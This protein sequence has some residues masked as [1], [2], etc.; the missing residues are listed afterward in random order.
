MTK[1]CS[2]EKHEAINL[3]V[4]KVL[5]VLLK[6][7]ETKFGDEQYETEFLGDLYARMIVSVY[8]GYFPHKMGE[9]AEAGAVRLMELNGVNFEET[10][11]DQG[12]A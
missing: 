3:H 5:K 1:E 2:E 10:E 12:N 4:V 6:D 8:M 9:D 11:D 7:L